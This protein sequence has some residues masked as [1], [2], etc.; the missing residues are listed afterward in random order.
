MA[1]KKKPPNQHRRCRC[2]SCEG[3]WV[4]AYSSTSRWSRNHPMVET[5]LDSWERFNRFKKATWRNLENSAVFNS[6]HPCMEKSWYRHHGQ[7]L[8]PWLFLVRYMQRQ[9]HAPLIGSPAR[10]QF[11]LFKGVF[12]SNRETFAGFTTQ[13]QIKELGLQ[14]QNTKCC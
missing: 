14:R 8:R 1:L 9:R 13:N 10:Q 12:F 3:T 5:A 4:W 11:G 6:T 7:V 2:L